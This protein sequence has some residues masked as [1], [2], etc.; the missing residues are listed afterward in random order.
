MRLQMS[1]ELDD[2]LTPTE[3][4]RLVAKPELQSRALRVVMGLSRARM[5][6]VD[7]RGPRT[8]NVG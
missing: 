7:H 4:A 8:M 3:R 2:R 5:P 6:D 1:N